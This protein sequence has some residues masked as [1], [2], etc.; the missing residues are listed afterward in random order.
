MYLCTTTSF[1]GVLAV[2]VLVSIVDGLLQGVQIIGAMYREDLCLRAAA[3]IETRC[4]RFA[5]INQGLEASVSRGYQRSR[6]AS[7]PREPFP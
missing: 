7:V 1:V 4:G 5:P 6:L 2:A 3:A